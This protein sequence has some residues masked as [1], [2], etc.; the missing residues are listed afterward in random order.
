MAVRARLPERH[1]LDVSY[2]DLIAEPVKVLE[3]VHR[4]AGLEFGEQEERT[5]R[6]TSE[7]NVQHRFGRHRY[8]L[9]EF[10]LD[11]ELLERELGFYRSHYGIPI[12]SEMRRQDAPAED[13][14]ER[15][16]GA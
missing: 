11:D 12:E 14:E 8:S 4:F 7:R 1:F 13:G 6:Q 2:Y 9:E 5:A 16:G 3:A 15:E 10:G